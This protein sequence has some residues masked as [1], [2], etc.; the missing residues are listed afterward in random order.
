MDA[1]FMMPMDE[2]GCIFAERATSRITSFQ[3]IIVA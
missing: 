1:K 2:R 3:R